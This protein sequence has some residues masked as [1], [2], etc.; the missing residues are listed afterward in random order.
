MRDL[1]AGL[2]AVQ[3]DHSL[4]TA[5]DRS[6][7][8]STWASWVIGACAVH[9]VVTPLLVG[10]LPLIGL[11]FFASEWFEWGMWGVAAV[12]GTAGLGLSFLKV[13]RDAIPVAVFGVGLAVNAASHLWFEDQEPTHA[14][15]A[16]AGALVILLAG[17]LNHARV[18]ACQACHPHPHRH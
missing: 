4:A 17:R 13:H 12:L 2:A 11:A 15:L 3:H 16:V 14:L 9:C 10:V 6:Y 18:H 8:L 5:E 7:R 1:P